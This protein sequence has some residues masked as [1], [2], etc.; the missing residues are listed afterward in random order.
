MQNLSQ[1]DEYANFVVAREKIRVSRE[2]QGVSYCAWY[3]IGY[4][5][6]TSSLLLFLFFLMLEE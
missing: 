4:F 6:C 1:K 2:V 5:N 3:L